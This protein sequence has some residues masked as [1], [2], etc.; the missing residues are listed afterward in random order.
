MQPVARPGPVGP[1]GRER[2]GAPPILVVGTTGDPATPYEGAAAMASALGEGV[3]VRVTYRGEGHGAY[4]G[5]D[6]CV[7]R[8]VDGYL[9]D[10]KVPEPGTVCP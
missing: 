6:A 2:P 9:L 1:P 4:N 5:G 8:V 3:G 7:R 10:G